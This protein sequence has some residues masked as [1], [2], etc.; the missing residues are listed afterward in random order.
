MASDGV[1]LV[2]ERVASTE[3]LTVATLNCWG[4]PFGS[5]AVLSRPGQL[6]QVVID[7]VLNGEKLPAQDRIVLCVQEAWAFK[8][9]I[10]GPAL[11]LA[12][13]LEKCCPTKCTAPK[14][15]VFDDSHLVSEILRV[16]S[17]CTLCA[18]L[19]ALI[20][21][22]CCPMPWLSYDQTRSDLLV[23]LRPYGLRHAI[24][25]NGAAGLSWQYQK[26]MD[27]GLL[28]L[29][30]EA[31]RASGFVGYAPPL[32][33]ESGVHK[34]ILWALFDGGDD[35]GSEVQPCTRGF[36]VHLGIILSPP[37]DAIAANVSVRVSCARSLCVSLSPSLSLFNPISSW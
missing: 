37:R 27:S 32:A 13:I 21:S 3:S 9:G 25:T 11:H 31:P 34:G 22:R 1:R 26:L 5:H 30:S 28:I 14:T 29:S 4:M 23:A 33:E 16:N 19:V 24:G 8:C 17:G 35:G 36:D 7:H 10:G 6:A 18:Q 20:T 15:N 12:S 2:V